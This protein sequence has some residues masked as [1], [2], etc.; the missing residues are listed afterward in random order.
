MDYDKASMEFDKCLNTI[1]D[2]IVELSSDRPRAL[3]H[4]TNATGMLGVIDRRRLWATHYQYLN[5]TSELDY[6]YS[7][8]KEIIKCFLDKEENDIVKNLL[9]NSLNNCTISS[10]GFEIYIAC[11]CEHDDVL[12]Q[13][14][15]YTG[16]S[17]GYALGFDANA[18]GRRTP[19]NP[20]QDFILRKVIYDEGKQRELISNA[21]KSISEKL[22]TLKIEG[23]S[24]SAVAAACKT[25]RMALIEMTVFFKHPA[26]SVEHEWRAL[27]MPSYENKSDLKFRDGIYGLTPYVELDISA[28][29]GVNSDK[30]PL[31]SITAAPSKYTNNSYLALKKLIEVKQLSFCAIRQST[32]PVRT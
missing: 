20:S 19:Q 12:N 13:W 3:Y 26:Y 29:H 25:L 27:H 5:D 32:L 1:I 11:F 16:T 23:S 7:I 10:S 4:Y 24:I 18:I 22:R 14:R 31:T 21:I 2:E 9:A 8:A 28:S 6:G 30:L 17:Q 15:V